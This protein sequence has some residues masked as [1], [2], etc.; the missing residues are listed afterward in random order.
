MKTYCDRILTRAYFY[1]KITSRYLFSDSRQRIV[2]TYYVLIYLCFFTTPVTSFVLYSGTTPKLE[3]KGAHMIR[4]LSPEERK[5]V[6]NYCRIVL[7]FPEKA[8]T[9]ITLDQLE[10]SIPICHT[11]VRGIK[12]L[13]DL[14]LRKRPS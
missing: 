5:V 12:R 1:L 10:H 13:K 8:K 7:V 6:M 4:Q 14:E 3:Y 2:F 9:M 11:L